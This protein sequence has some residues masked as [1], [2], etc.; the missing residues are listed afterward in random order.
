MINFNSDFF[1]NCEVIEG[2]VKNT[3]AASEIFTDTAS[4][5]FPGVPETIGKRRINFLLKG[6]TS[7]YSSLKWEIKR[8]FYCKDKFDNNCLI[9]EWDVNGF[10]KTG[11]EYINQGISVITFESD[12]CEKIKHFKDY[13]TS[14]DFSDV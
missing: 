11:K 4:F 9:V 7:R 14:T 3:K 1:L 6:I 2:I 13:F 8:E 10:F 12:T 5:L